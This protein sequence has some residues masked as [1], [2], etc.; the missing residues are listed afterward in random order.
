[1]RETT[2]R[3]LP[4]VAA[5]FVTIATVPAVAQAAVGRLVSVEGAVQIDA[6]G[7]GAFIGARPGEILYK[8]SVLRVPADGTAALEI[9]KTTHQAPPG[10]TLR[11]ADLV[12]A[13]ERKAGLRWIDAL[14]RMVSSVARSVRGSEEEVTLGSRAA[15]KGDTKRS[16]SWSVEEDD[17]EALYRT[18]REKAASGDPAGA[19]KDLLA[20]EAGSADAY[21]AAELAFWRGHCYFELGAHADA[22]THLAAARRELEADPL[23]IDP[24]VAR[25]GLLELGASQYYLGRPA[26]SVATFRSLVREKKADERTLYAY[27]FLIEALNGL[28]DR[29]GATAELRDAQTL[30][31]GSASAS[32]LADLQ[33]KLSL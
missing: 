26:D 7:K 32:Q 24:G 30:F 25:L 28:G 2:R 8:E 5:L 3:L 4:V 15:D 12:G 6:F 16:V 27:L 10:A 1:M 17:D 9:G 19:L 13:V 11:V 21:S 29:T 20:V 22:L 14:G 31:A 33:R 23:S 18:G